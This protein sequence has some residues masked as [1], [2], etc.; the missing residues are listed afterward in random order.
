MIGLV[1]NKLALQQWQIKD[2][3]PCPTAGC[4]IIN[5][6]CR[7]S[8]SKPV[9]YGRNAFSAEEGQEGVFGAVPTVG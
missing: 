6:P 2:L 3:Q 5:E 1:T 8:Y 9:E 4:S 7:A